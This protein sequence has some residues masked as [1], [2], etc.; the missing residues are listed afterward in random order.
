MFVE[1]GISVHVFKKCHIP[2]K[3]VE[4]DNLI[5]LVD[6]GGEWIFIFR[7]RQVPSI[8]NWFE[9]GR[10]SNIAFQMFWRVVDWHPLSLLDG[11]LKL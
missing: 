10:V 1:F 3:V 4:E 6:S 5:G 7:R 9:F 11:P 8:S 2:L